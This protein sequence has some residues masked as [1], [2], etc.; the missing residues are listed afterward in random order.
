MLTVGVDVLVRNVMDDFAGDVDKRDVVGLGDV[1]DGVAGAVG[2]SSHT[3]VQ[4]VVAAFNVI[5]GELG[6]QVGDIWRCQQGQVDLLSRHLRVLLQEKSDDHEPEL[7]DGDEAK[8]SALMILLNFGR[9]DAERCL[10]QSWEIFQTKRTGVGLESLVIFKMLRLV[11]Y[12]PRRLL[13]LL[14]SPGFTKRRKRGNLCSRL[15]R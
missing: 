11:V 4:A 10:D 5:D 12:H 3:N 14:V 9:D 8:R 1:E 2:E 7:N 13:I 15:W 6:E